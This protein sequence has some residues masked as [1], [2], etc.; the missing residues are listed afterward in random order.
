MGPRTGSAIHCP[1]AEQLW[2]NRSGRAHP[3]SSKLAHRY[4]CLTYGSEA[5]LL[6]VD[7]MNW[8]S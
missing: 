1:R 3:P 8:A 6:T 5:V 4:P 7:E 2:R